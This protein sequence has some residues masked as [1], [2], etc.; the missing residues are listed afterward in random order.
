M[1][2]FPWDVL[3]IA[4]TAD[5]KLIRAAYAIR[6]KQIGPR[7]D[8]AAFQRLRSAYELAMRFGGP[9]QTTVLVVERRNEALAEITALLEAGDALAA[10]RRFDAADASALTFD[11]LATIEERLLL[12]APD[13]PRAPLLALVHRF[14]WDHAIHP[15]RSRHDAV[16]VQ[17]DQRLLLEQWR[18]ELERAR[19]RSFVAAVLLK[20]PPVWH[21]YL[22]ACWR[23]MFASNRIA[24]IGWLNRIERAPHA[25]EVFERARLCWCRRWLQPWRLYAL[26][27]GGF[28]LVSPLAAISQGEIA[29]GV[30]AWTISMATLAL[31]GGIAVLLTRGFRRLGRAAWFLVGALRGK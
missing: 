17:L 28:S 23:L 19:P 24:A 22:F 11:E 26:I 9:L 20:G 25:G 3:G 29:A 18:A 5:A 21:D 2:G 8:A 31:V 10:V 7:T 1:P 15:L 27:A 14:D 6:L 13:L 4:P 16:F 30:L 12:Q